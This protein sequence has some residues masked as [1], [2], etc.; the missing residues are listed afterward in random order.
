[1]PGPAIFNCNLVYAWSLLCKISKIFTFWQTNYIHSYHTPSH[2]LPRLYFCPRNYYESINFSRCLQQNS[3][4]FIGLLWVNLIFL[5]VYL[6]CVKISFLFKGWQI[7]S[8]LFIHVWVASVSSLLQTKL[9]WL[10]MYSYTC[11]DLG[12][13]FLWICPEQ[14]DQCTIW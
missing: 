9:L 4:F 2:I 6:W 1:M 7:F 13:Q 11:R 3:S 5:K 12:F 10:R 8:C 14:W